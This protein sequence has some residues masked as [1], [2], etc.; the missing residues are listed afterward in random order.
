[1]LLFRNYPRGEENKASPPDPSPKGEGS[2]EWKSP[3]PASPRGGECLPDG[4]PSPSGELEGGISFGFSED[5]FDSFYF[6]SF[7]AFQ[8]ILDDGT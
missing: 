3:L 2:E 7:H 4:F 1:M 6:L 8:H 5:G